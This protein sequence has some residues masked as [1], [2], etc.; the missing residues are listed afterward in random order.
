MKYTIGIVV[1]SVVFL[2]PVFSRKK[3]VAKVAEVEVMA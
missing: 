1:A 2:A 3:G